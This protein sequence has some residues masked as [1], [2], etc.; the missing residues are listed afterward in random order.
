MAVET[1][2]NNQKHFLC[3]LS[4]FSVSCGLNLATSFDWFSEKSCY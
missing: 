2:Q 1:P 3:F 4:Y